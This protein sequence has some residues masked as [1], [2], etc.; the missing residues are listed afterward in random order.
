MGNSYANITVSGPPQADVVA[1]L[2]A[3]DRHAYVTPTLNGITI[4]FDRASEDSGRPEELG[5][6]AMTLSQDLRC[7]AL[8]TAVFDD[9]VL[10][11]GLY[12]RGAQVG[13]YNS[14]GSSTLRAS[15]LSRAFRATTRAPLVWALLACP[16]VPIFTFESFRHRILLRLLQ[17][18]TWAFATGYRYISRGE[19]PEDLESSALLHVNGQA[20]G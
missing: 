11:L 5:D 10:L 15:S 13:E 18:P 1:V 2:Q 6:L 17:Q 20:P 9:D 3:H 4:V 14:A 8:A 7:P 12:D 16:R 19:P